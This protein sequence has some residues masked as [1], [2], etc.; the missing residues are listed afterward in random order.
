MNQETCPIHAIASVQN[1]TLTSLELPTE[2]YN[3]IYELAAASQ[4]RIKLTYSHIT[5]H[6][7]NRDSAFALMRVCRQIRSEFQPSCLAESKL[8]IELRDLK[9]FLTEFFH[10]SSEVEQTLVF[11]M[12]V[13]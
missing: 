5:S 1:K 2:L 7:R 4:K 11:L 13:I 3:L 9:L 6:E 12:I 10:V 8:T